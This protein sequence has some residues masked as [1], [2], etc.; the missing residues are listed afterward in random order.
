MNVLTLEALRAVSRDTPVPLRI[1]GGCMTPL[2]DDGANVAVRARRLY[3]PGDV[4]VFRTKAGDLAAHRMLG[5]RAAG[6]VTKGDGCV[7]HDPPV[8]R[9]HIVGA[10]EVRV[11][12]R[13]RVRAVRELAR[14]IGRRLL[15]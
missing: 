12:L 4:L 14:I 5:W 13:D 11:A 10:V 3:L 15:R 7:V 1:R 8:A 9:A 2:M 6:F